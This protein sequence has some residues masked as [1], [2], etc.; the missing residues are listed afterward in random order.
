VIDPALLDDDGR[1]VFG[2]TVELL[3]IAA[4]RT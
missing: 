1:V 2:S 3:D 4:R